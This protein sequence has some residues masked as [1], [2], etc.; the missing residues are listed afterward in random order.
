MTEGAEN[1]P[2]IIK[3]NK[4]EQPDSTNRELSPV[5]SGENQKKYHFV[6]QGSLTYI[7]DEVGNKV[8]D[9][10]HEFEIFKAEAQGGSEIRGILARLGA[11][12]KVLSPPTE[13][14]PRFQASEEEFHAVQYRPDLGGVFTT[15]TGA[16]QHI[17]GYDGK[18]ASKDFHDIYRSGDKIY[19][20]VGARVEE[21]SRTVAVSGPAPKLRLSSQRGVGPD[22]KWS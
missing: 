8:S 12:K 10:Y 19:G 22:D 3:S 17:I 16:M 7:V 9:G 2:I 21:I 4:G 5:I 20:R 13:N 15:Q 6:K 14:N 11:M 1:L 18:P